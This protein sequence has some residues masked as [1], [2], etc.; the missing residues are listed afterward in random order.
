V[1]P[2]QDIAGQSDELSS[3]ESGDNPDLRSP[4]RRASGVSVC[5]GREV[6]RATSA[7][8]KHGLA[9]RRPVERIRVAKCRTCAEGRP[10]C[11]M[12]GDRAAGFRLTKSIRFWHD[13]SSGNGRYPSGR[14]VGANG[15]NRYVRRDAQARITDPRPDHGRRCCRIRLLISHPRSVHSLGA[16]ARPPTATDQDGRA[17]ESK[18]FR[19][20]CWKYP[21]SGRAKTYPEII[22]ARRSS[23]EV[24]GSQFGQEKAGTGRSGESL[25]FCR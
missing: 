18:E 23:G 19:F 21:S 14:K 11:S 6:A 16:R 5:P 2:V 25:G 9:T 4:S 7:S 15:T 13:E 20:S 24:S 10:L 22:R 12:M 17:K 3:W 8:G 1:L